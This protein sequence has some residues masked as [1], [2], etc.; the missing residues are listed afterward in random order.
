MKCL[1]CGHCNRIPINKVFI[2]QPSIESKV[3]VLI[4][5]YEPLDRINM[6]M[7]IDHVRICVIYC[8]LN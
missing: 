3:K 8:R 6:E 5:F 2:E 1:N 7:W 4:T